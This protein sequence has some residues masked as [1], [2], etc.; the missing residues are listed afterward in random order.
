M[1]LQSSN[2]K[3]QIEHILEQASILK[4]YA[5][6]DL[7]DL[8]IPVLDDQDLAAAFSN[9]IETK[10]KNNKA[11][12]SD[13]ES[14][15]K[16]LYENW[17]V[18]YNFPD[19]NG[20]PFKSSGGEMVWNKELK[21]MIPV[22]WD[23]EE[24]G[25]IITTEKGISYNI[26]DIES[27][28]GI[29]ML[30]SASFM[31]GGGNYCAD[32]LMHYL[33]KYPKDNVLKPYDLIMNY[34]QQSVDIDKM[35]FSGTAMLVPDIFKENV[36]FSH[37]VNVIRT[38]NEDLKYYLMYWFNSVVNHN[39]ILINPN[40]PA[41]IEF[42][43]LEIP[44]PNL[45]YRFGKLIFEIEKK[46][47]DKL[48]E[49]EKLVSLRDLLLPMLNN[50][51]NDVTINNVDKDF[52]RLHRQDWIPVIEQEIQRQ[53]E[54]TGK[55][56][57]TD[58]IEAVIDAIANRF[59]IS[60]ASV[61]DEMLDNG[62]SAAAGAFNVANGKILSPFRT[63]TGTFNSNYTYVI[64]IDN[65]INVLKTNEELRRCIHEG[66]YR[67]IDGHLLINNQKYYCENEA[68]QIRLSDYARTH[69]EECC[70]AFAIAPPS[71]I[72]SPFKHTGCIMM[73]DLTGTRVVLRPQYTGGIE[74][75]NIEN[76]K[77]EFDAWVRRNAELKNKLTYSITDNLNILLSEANISQRELAKRLNKSESTI[78]RYFT[79]TKK[80]DAITLACICLA[81]G[82]V[83]Y[84]VC[85][86][87]FNSYNQQLDMHSESG[88]W[89]DAALQTMMGNSMKEVIDFLAKH[90][91]MI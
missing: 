4:D 45:L 24:V 37:N 88:I 53:Q 78:S 67:Y 55:M 51:S 47:R 1:G 7:L 59:D 72:I 81:L 48:L 3:Q 16:L 73:M 19:K 15:A 38:Q 46:K 30:D 9:S 5:I 44:T 62:Y 2:A 70:I 84:C 31:P 79:G 23:V 20:K 58:I 42:C 82:C 90:N 56:E 64:D 33:G 27:G 74:N 87:L 63:S 41:D 75:S 26:P 36:I 28:E 39:Q 8:I 69:I 85:E 22:G 14:M 35:S 83:P 52:H 40:G 57:I 66:L 65:L 71:N 10:L 68:H 50:G 18:Q 76:Q 49:N 61:Q 54:L 32:G 86:R 77:K 29:P 21:R 11:I 13:L 12:C 43:L 60:R 25:N 80:P 91:V 6:G 34:T 89:I 17:F